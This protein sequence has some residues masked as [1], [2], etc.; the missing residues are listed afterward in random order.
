MLNG[1]FTLAFDTYYRQ[2]DNIY[3]EKDLSSTTSFAQVSS[4][5]ISNVN[6]GWEFQLNA[7]P[8]NDANKD[9]KWNLSGSLSINRE[10]L[11]ALPD[12]LAE[13]IYQ[14]ASI[15]D[16]D[17]YYRLGLNSLSNYLYN[18][19]GVYA[20]NAQ[21]PVD[22]VTGLPYRV[23]A[24]ALLNYFKAGDPIFTDLDGNYVLDENDKVIAG[25]SQPQIT[26]GLSSLFR[27]K[28]WSLEVNTSF[29]FQRDILNNALA[30]QFLNFTTPTTLGNLVPLSQYNYWAAPNDIATYGN[31]FDFVRASILNPFR[32]SQTLFQEDGSYFKIN[33]VKLYYNLNQSFT[34]RYGM[35]R[36]SLNLTAS[37][38]GFITNYSGPN[39]EAVTALGRDSSGGYPLSKQFTLGLNVEF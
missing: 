37:N 20:T 32:Y 24:S 10:V 39:P 27:Y 35:N 6:Y 30:A 26:G 17:T 1:R 38:L 21:V 5:D 22:P 36:V 31:P 28:N 33:S 3:K 9:F 4:T 29:T 16:Q 18:T 14:D 11:A 13:K 2:T 8:L 25:N 23:G 7:R 15:Y 12:G 19:K 34:R